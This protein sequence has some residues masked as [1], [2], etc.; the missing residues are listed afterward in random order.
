[1]EFKNNDK[2]IYK[3]IDDFFAA[4]HEETML[5][6]HLDWEYT[7]YENFENLCLPIAYDIIIFYE[8][9]QDS[10]QRELFKLEEWGA[11]HVESSKNDWINGTL[12]EL[13]PLI[14]ATR[15]PFW[16]YYPKKVVL[17]LR[18][19]THIL[20][21]IVAL[22]VTIQFMEPFLGDTSS[23]NSRFI[24]ESSLITDASEKL[25]AYIE[26]TLKPTSNNYIF[27]L[28]L[29]LIPAVLT[30]LLTKASR[31]IFPPSMILIGCTQSKLKYKL[32][33]YNFIWGA[34][35]TAIIGLVVVNIISV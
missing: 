35:I 9:E 1:M 21:W 23:L 33:A 5:R 32:V 8:I 27:F 30:V 2:L 16:W 7:I 6:V 34:I 24:E 26:Y 19:Y 12:K 29:V 20:I 4:N 25:Q 14:N 3:S 22:L 31:H 15:M 18:E 13:K 28:A 11:I 17:A 10:D